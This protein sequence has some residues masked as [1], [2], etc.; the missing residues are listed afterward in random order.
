MNRHT[1]AILFTI[2]ALSF[3]FSASAVRAESGLMTPTSPADDFVITVKTNNLGLSGST[4]F[5]IPTDKD[6]AS[7]NYRQSPCT[8]LL[9]VFATNG[10]NSHE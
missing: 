3:V 4:S 10:T 1:V 8:V 5:I 2:I 7:Y 9:F 6:I